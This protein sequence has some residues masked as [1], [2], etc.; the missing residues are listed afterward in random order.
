MSRRT[1]M[2]ALAT[3][4]VAALA[5]PAVASAQD[6]P[7]ATPPPATNPAP[8]PA[9]GGLVLSLQRGQPGDVLV[10]DTFRVRGV[11]RPYVAGQ[12]VIVRFFRGGR[13][14]AA[15]SAAVTPG[16]SGKA[17]FLTVPFATRKPGRLTIRAEHAATPAQ[18]A[19]RAQ[20]LRLPVLEYSARPGA[21][22]R[23]VR[24]LQARLAAQHYVVGR[25]GVYDERTARAVMAFRKVVG[26]AR[27]FDA[28]PEVFRRLDRGAGAYRLRYPRHGKHVEADLS[29]QVIVLARGGRVERIYPTS[30]GKPSTPTVLGSYRVYRKQY[31]TNSHGMVHSSYFIRGYAIH[32]YADVPS[33]AASHGCLRVPIPDALSI[34]DWVSLG[35]IVD[36]Y[37]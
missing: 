37:R 25:R 17:G 29:R 7:P 10:R 11:V 13:Q 34:Y 32:G 24:H 4:A 8:T 27:T 36:V 18:V 16:P 15:R 3:A 26:M 20:A 28:T 12:A 14:I 30:S 9:A 35:D 22:G 6:T 23:V 31:G 1:V 5:L 21:T 33:F 2:T 19:F